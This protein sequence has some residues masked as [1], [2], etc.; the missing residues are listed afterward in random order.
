M[1]GFDSP[2]DPRNYAEPGLLE[3][4]EGGGAGVADEGWVV[5]GGV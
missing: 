2:K 3:R 4:F 5:V 1:R